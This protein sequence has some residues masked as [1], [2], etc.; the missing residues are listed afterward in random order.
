METDHPSATVSAL[1][2][3]VGGQ[4]WALSDVLMSVM[5]ELLAVVLFYHS[6]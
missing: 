5:E 2:A 4:M 6:L 3:V 1:C